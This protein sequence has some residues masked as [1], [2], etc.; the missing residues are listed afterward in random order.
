MVSAHLTY[1]AANGLRSSQ[2]HSGVYNA[3]CKPNAHMEGSARLV[4]A[5]D[6]KS[7]R[8][9]CESEAHAKHE[10]GPAVAEV[11]KHRLADLRAATSVEDLVVGR[12]RQLDGA[13]DEHMVVDLCDGHRLVFCAN[14]LNKPVTESGKLDW[15]M[16]SRIK[17]LKIDSDHD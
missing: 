2:R 8:T 1:V 3:Q 6:S 11:L 10:L 15:Q 7:L 13:D 4:L 9:I 5:F 14:Q 16:V 17:I 12:P